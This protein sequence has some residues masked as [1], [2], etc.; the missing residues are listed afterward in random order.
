MAS[1][2]DEATSYAPEVGSGVVGCPTALRN[3]DSPSAPSGR[4]GSSV[5]VAA[6]EA[7]GA[8]SVN[9]TAEP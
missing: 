4:I 3:A 9:V 5:S 7:R 8:G 2:P 1:A 6:N